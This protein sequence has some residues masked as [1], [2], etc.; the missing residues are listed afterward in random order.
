MGFTQALFSVAIGFIMRLALPI[1]FLFLLSWLV[2]R[3][4]KPQIDSVLKDR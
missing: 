2:A 4:Q 1:G 3:I